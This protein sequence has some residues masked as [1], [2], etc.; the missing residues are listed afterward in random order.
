MSVSDFDELLDTVR[1]KIEKAYTQLRDP[2]SPGER[3]A[4]TLRYIFL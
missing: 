2:I 4:V 3:L 1:N